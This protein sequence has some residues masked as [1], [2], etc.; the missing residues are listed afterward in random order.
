LCGITGPLVVAAPA[1]V[2]GMF[3]DFF[4]RAMTDVGAIGPDRGRG[5]LYLILPPDFQGHVP[6]GYFV[7]RSSTYNVLLFF[8]T[9]MTE[10][11]RGP[12][13]TPPWKSPS[14]RAS[15]RAGRRR[16]RRR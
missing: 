9:V 13:R 2:F 15:I 5:G 12:T 4:Q 7:F 1:G 6:D 8:R 16:R 11:P 3:T 10:G 14:A